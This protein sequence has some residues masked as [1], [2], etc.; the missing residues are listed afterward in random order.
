MRR[1]YVA[2]VA[3]FAVPTLASAQATEWREI[4]K[5]PLRAFVPQQ[6]R[7][8]ALPNGLVIFLQEDH[9]LPLVRGT[10][11]IRG[12]SREEPAAKVGLLGVYG[13]AWRTGGTKTSVGRPRDPLRP[14][15][16]SSTT[17]ACV[18]SVVF[19][20]ATIWPR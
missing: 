16:I 6:P 14:A 7:R 10:A 5:P 13:Q 4:R 19:T 1:T 2:L 17:W 9:E 20:W 8:I 12:G 15:V 18:T 11:R 3:A